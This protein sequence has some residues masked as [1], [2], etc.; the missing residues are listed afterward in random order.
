MDERAGFF[1]GGD[2]AMGSGDMMTGWVDCTPWHWIVFAGFIALFLYPIGRI[3]SRLGFSPFWS[4]LA[5][6]PLANL[7]GLWL[8]AISKWPRDNPA[9]R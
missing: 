8:L 3:L 5:L 4:V 7:L 2:D 9:Q 6:V 1:S